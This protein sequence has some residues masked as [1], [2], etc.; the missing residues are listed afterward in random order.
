MRFASMVVCSLNNSG[1][2]TALVVR[3]SIYPSDGAEV[4]KTPV[5]RRANDKRIDSVIMIYPRL[6]VPG[7]RDRDPA[8]GLI[9]QPGFFR[10]FDLSYLVKHAYHIFRKMLNYS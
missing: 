7:R 2:L 9:V 1:F 6:R 5:Y 4:V 8:P 3:L 10:S